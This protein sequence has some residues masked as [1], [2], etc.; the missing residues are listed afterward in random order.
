VGIKQT[1]ALPASVIT[2]RCLANSDEEGSAML[3]AGDVT[4]GSFGGGFMYTNRD[5]ISLGIVA[6]IDAVSKSRYPIYQ[7]MEDFKAHPQIAA[8]I[9]GAELVEHAGHMVPE[10][11]LNIMPP[12]VGDGVL[13]A[14]EAAMMCINF[15]Y[16][17]RGMDYAVAAGQMAGQAAV[18]A[19]DAGDTSA[20]GLHSYIDALEASFVM[21]DLRQFASEPEFLGSFNR[22]FRG[23]P[24]M[25]GGIMEDMLIIDG[26]PA[27]RMKDIAYPWL[28]AMGVRNMLKDVRGALK[29]L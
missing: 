10:G 11:G 13:V 2:D 22:M 29:A 15:G 27:Q 9:R 24:E 3:V 23:Y 7:M 19:L 21:K 26:R 6:G 18:R 16:A 5:T 17:V 1:F 14:G 4:K 25:L 28:R 12:L 20:A 8:Y